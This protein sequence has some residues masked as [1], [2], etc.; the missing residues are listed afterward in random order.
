[1]FIEEGFRIRFANG[2]VI[3]FYAESKAKKDEWMSMLDGVIGSASGSDIPKWCD[4]VLKREEAQRRR[5]ARKISAEK[6]GD[7]ERADNEKAVRRSRGAGENEVVRPL[8]AP[9]MRSETDGPRPNTTEEIRQRGET[10]RGG[11][12]GM[13]GMNPLG[14][15]DGR[16]RSNTLA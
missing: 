10:Y 14:D 1:M 9:H 13:T 15:S 5:E 7:R 2:E 16:T 6:R 8:M 4:E 11:R 3:D 12:P